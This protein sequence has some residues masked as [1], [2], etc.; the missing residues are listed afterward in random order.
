MENLISGLALIGAIVAIFFQVK[1]FKHQARIMAIAAK[2]NARGNL[3]EYYFK[4]RERIGDASAGVTIVNEINDKL[5]ENADLLEEDLE[6][7]N[8]LS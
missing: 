6:E 4:K 7:L 8:K 3:N 2:I 1:E 5:I